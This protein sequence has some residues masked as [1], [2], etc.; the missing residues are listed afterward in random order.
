MQYMKLPEEIADEIADQ[1]FSVA[2]LFHAD[3]RRRI[4]RAIEDERKVTRY[5]ATQMGR[6]VNDPPERL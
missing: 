4:I 2:S 6:W 3:L 5:Y 1:F